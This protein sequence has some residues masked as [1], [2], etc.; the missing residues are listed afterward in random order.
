MPNLRV[1]VLPLTVNLHDGQQVRSTRTCNVVVPRLPQPLRGH[2][3]LDLAMA[4]LFG[5]RPLCN[6][7]YIVV[8]HKDQDEVQYNGKI[9]FVGPKNMSMD[10]WTLPIT[11]AQVKSQALIPSDAHDAM[12]TAIAAFLHLVQTGVNAVRFAHQSYQR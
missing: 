6:V 3:I 9:I 4:S 8:F 2:D 12:Q 5:I 1:A 7:G 11:P 10:L